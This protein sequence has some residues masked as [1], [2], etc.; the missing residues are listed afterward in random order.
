MSLKSSLLAFALTPHGIWIYSP[1]PGQVGY[2]QINR[3]AEPVQPNWGNAGD[4]SWCGF[5]CP[6]PLWSH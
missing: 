5:T 1:D 6:K 3:P 2:C 4:T